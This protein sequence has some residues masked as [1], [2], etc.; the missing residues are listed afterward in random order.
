MQRNRLLPP[1]TDRTSQYLLWCRTSQ[2]CN[3]MLKITAQ[4]TTPQTAPARVQSD[5]YIISRPALRQRHLS[6]S[7]SSIIMRTV[8]HSHRP[9]FRPLK[10]VRLMDFNEQKQLNANKLANDLSCVRSQETWAP[11]RPRP[12]RR[13][14]RRSRTTAGASKNSLSK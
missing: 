11:A 8:S 4:T 1:P 13:P 6:S 9:R 10:M 7:S 2:D 14:T 12:A 5:K 3:P